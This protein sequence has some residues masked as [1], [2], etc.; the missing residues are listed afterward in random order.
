M[1]KMTDS[2]IKTLMD[3]SNDPISEAIMQLNKQQQMNQMLGTL[4]TTTPPDEKLR[5]I[6]Y[7]VLHLL[8]ET[9]NKFDWLP[10]YNKIS[11]NNFITNILKKKL[12]VISHEAVK[13]VR[14]W[15][16]EIDEKQIT[17]KSEICL[18]FLRWC[19]AVCLFKECERKAAPSKRKLNE[20]KN[21]LENLQNK[22]DEFNLKKDKCDKTL[23]EFKKK[24][25]RNI[26]STQAQKSEQER[27][28][29]L[30]A[31]AR[32]IKEIKEEFQGRWTTMIESTNQTLSK[33]IGD[34]LIISTILA[35]EGD[36]TSQQSGEL[37]AKLI[38]LLENNGI[39]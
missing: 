34:S 11:D 1:I 4:R 31:N 12:E 15:T 6:I 29:S 30:I 16:S 38:Y 24:L 28:G 26:S 17:Q 32:V 33:L 21:K 22:E 37:Y 25:D 9:F 10:A 2:E 36:L 8:D 14:N 20:L 19:K 3:P 35:F 13:K 7:S 27:S 5:K 39:K 18:I 23:E